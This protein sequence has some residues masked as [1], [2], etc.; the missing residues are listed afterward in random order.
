MAIILSDRITKLE[1]CLLNS[2]TIDQNIMINKA[3]EFCI[4]KYETEPGIEVMRFIEPG[5]INSWKLRNGEV[6][7]HTWFLPFP[8]SAKD[9]INF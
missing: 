1:K 7:K 9:E 2:A 8:L 4:I 6:M 5:Q 3:E